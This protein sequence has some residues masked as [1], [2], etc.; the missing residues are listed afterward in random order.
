MWASIFFAV[1]CANLAG[2]VI[3]EECSRYHY[4]AQ[5]LER[6]IRAESGLK[7]LK[8][9]V[10]I[11]EEKTGNVNENNAKLSKLAEKVDL[12]QH[13]MAGL[14]KNV[15]SIQ[16]EKT[17]SM[18]QLCQTNET[19]SDVENSECKWMTCKCKPG[20]SYHHET[21][22]C[23]TDCGDHGYGNTF[24][25][26]LDTTIKGFNDKSITSISLEDCVQRCTMEQ[27]FVCKTVEYG[28]ANKLC[29]L[30]RET[31]YTKAKFYEKANWQY[32]I[33]TRDCN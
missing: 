23:L 26:E 3:S 4:E 24:Q 17:S 16:E 28:K 27:R 18:R 9:H 31:L 12:L 13:N 32:I 7:A 1:C 6:V 29:Q 30:S 10:T 14:L 25:V 5:T 21:K 22:T 19:C 33:Y 8:T 15:S 11:I 2:S 20:L